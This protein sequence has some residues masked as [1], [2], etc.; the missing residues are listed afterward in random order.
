[1]VDGGGWVVPTM[2]F[3][4]PPAF[5]APPGLPECDADRLG[6]LALTRGQGRLPAASAPSWDTPE[7]W[8]QERGYSPEAYR[9]VRARL[10]AQAEPPA[11][12]AAKAENV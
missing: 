11:D 12:D 7:R 4:A 8:A 5:T 2:A 3:P 1:V 9:E 10:E 6:L